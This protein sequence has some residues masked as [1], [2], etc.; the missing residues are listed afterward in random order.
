MNLFRNYVLILITFFI[1]S[2]CYDITPEIKEQYI[3]GNVKKDL[4]KVSEEVVY[5]QKNDIKILAKHPDG[6]KA[7]PYTLNSDIGTLNN[8]V[9]TSYFKQYFN[10]V[11]YTDDKKDK[12]IYIKSYI[13]DYNFVYLLGY[14]IELKTQVHIEAYYD[15]QQ[16]INKD[17]VSERNIYAMMSTGVFGDANLFTLFSEVFHEA[18]LNVYKNEFQKDMLTAL[19]TKIPVK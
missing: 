2:G 16:V 10:N 17:Y 3:E 1:F 13:K 19:K 7:K 8:F 5:F 9:G 6:I 18:V 14:A 11:S 12:G 4:R 15:G